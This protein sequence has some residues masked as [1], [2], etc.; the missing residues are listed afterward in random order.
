MFLLLTLSILLSSLAYAIPI[1]IAIA[2]E[3]KQNNILNSMLIYLLSFIISI[4]IFISCI[5]ILVFFST[6]FIK[7]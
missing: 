3:D 6:K 5:F 1:H 2:D 7:K 4:L